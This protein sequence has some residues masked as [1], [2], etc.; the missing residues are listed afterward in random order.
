MAWLTPVQIYI[1]VQN[2]VDIPEINWSEPPK[3]DWTESDYINFW[4][5]NRIEQ[6]T[7]DL[8]NYLN[9]LFFLIPDIVTIVNR[10]N[11]SFDYL[12]SINRIEGNLELMKSLLAAPLEWQ[13]TKLWK[14]G[15][16]FTFE[17]ANRLENSLLLLADLGKLAYKNYQHCGTVTC[18]EGGLI[19]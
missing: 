3:T 19:Y 9:N 17:D 13:P 1:P 15:M 10:T 8:R 2:V 6:N 5:F 7:I 14:V 16:G 18:G 4:D 12:S 11:Y